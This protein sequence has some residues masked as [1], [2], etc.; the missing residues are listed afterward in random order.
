MARLC[1]NMAWLRHRTAWLRCN[2]TWL[3]YNI[4][5]LRRNLARLRHNLARLRHNLAW[6]IIYLTQQED[7]CTVS[8]M[9]RNDEP[10]TLQQAMIY[11]ADQDNCL[12]YLVARRWP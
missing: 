2:T 11:F 1:R 9:K 12:N 3:R 8:C 7:S 4:N 6:A 10:K 5:W